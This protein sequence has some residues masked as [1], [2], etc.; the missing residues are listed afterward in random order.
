MTRRVARTFARLHYVLWLVALFSGPVLGEK[1]DDG[2]TAWRDGRY[3][4]AL[5]IWT[6]LAK[7]GDAALQ[8]NVGWMYD[9]GKGA[10]EDN[11]VAI[12]WYRLAAEQNDFD[13]IYRLIQF[14][15]LGREVRRD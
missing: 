1:I 9:H 4:D 8:F 14:F 15:G 5:R 11:V 2:Y 10:P 7:Q 3:S 6:P 12:N 13:A